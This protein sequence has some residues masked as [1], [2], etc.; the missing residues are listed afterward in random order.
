M[1]NIYQIREGDVKRLIESSMAHKKER[2]RSLISESPHCDVEAGMLENATNDNVRVEAERMLRHVFD[3]D[4]TSVC[5]RRV[6]IMNH[7]QEICGE[8]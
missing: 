1:D 4:F 7:E 8:N 5:I 3:F 2:M 6:K